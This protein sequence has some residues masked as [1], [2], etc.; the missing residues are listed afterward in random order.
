[1][2]CHFVTALNVPGIGRTKKKIHAPGSESAQQDLNEFEESFDIDISMEV[3]AF[4]H[5]SDALMTHSSS[6]RLSLDSVTLAS[7][8]MTHVKID[9]THY[10]ST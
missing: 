4:C 8:Q 2:A 6:F 3:E 9:V 10:D 7:G 1:M 5:E